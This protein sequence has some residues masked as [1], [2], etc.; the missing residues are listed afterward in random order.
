MKIGIIGAG[1]VATGLGKLW[2]KN[3]HE[4]FFG[5]SRDAEKL[6]KTALSVSPSAKSGS[7]QEAVAFG[8][9]VV[10]AV[11]YS[12]VPDA[13]AAAGSLA[14]K[15]LFSRVNALKADYSGLAVGCVRYSDLAHP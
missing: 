14:G 11:P 5:Y 6:K 13:M 1:N 10:L 7:P 12:A 4:L 9:V 3:G 8:D 15:L 2:D